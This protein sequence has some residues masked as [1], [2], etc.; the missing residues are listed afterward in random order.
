MHIFTCDFGQC[1]KSF[2]FQDILDLGFWYNGLL[3]GRTNPWE[4]AGE[5]LEGQEEM[6]THYADWNNPLH[7]TTFMGHFAFV[8]IL[9]E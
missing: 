6:I 9:Y 7:Q 2:V 5:K 1:W 3:K 8:I 4:C